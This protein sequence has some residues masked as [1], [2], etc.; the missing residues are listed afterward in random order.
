MKRF[1]LLIVCLLAVSR[2]AGA[3]ETL[4]FSQSSDFG[5]IVVESS[6]P[7]YSGLPVINLGSSD[8]LTV[9]FDDLADRDMS[10]RYRVVHLNTD[11]TS[12]SLRE[13]E[14]VNGINKTD[15]TDVNLSFNPRTN[16]VHYQFRFPEGNR[17]AKVSGAAAGRPGS[18]P[19]AET[20]VWA[21]GYSSRI[22][23]AMNA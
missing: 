7:D 14:Y 22:V 9:G 11:G 6:N 13:I 17:Y 4:D 19:I 1:C 2:F 8:Y 23:P 21:S 5:S 12:S 18:S 16:Y 15:I 20:T 10:L 3:Q